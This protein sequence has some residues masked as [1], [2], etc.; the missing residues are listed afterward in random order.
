[1]LKSR[2]TS[3]AYSVNCNVV[4]AWIVTSSFWC[5]QVVLLLYKAGRELGLHCVLYL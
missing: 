1:M 3:I 5:W 2:L 4:R